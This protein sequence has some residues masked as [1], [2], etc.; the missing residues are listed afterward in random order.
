MTHR[1]LENTYISISLHLRIRNSF[2]VVNF[3]EVSNWHSSKPQIILGCNYF[4]IIKCNHFILW[5]WIPLTYKLLCIIVI[6]FDTP[7]QKIYSKI[8]KIIS[9]RNNFPV[10]KV[11]RSKALIFQFFDLRFLFCKK[12]AALFFCSWYFPPFTFLELCY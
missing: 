3:D 11:L 5:P 9:S 1:F 6:Q 8:N 10:Q 2:L 4:N 12:I 7:K